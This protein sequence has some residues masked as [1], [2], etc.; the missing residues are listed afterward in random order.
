V[1]VVAA[2]TTSA[3][4]ARVAVDRLT[5]IN[6]RVV[7]VVLNRAKVDARSAFYYPYGDDDERAA[8]ESLVQTA[9]S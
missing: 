1:F 6:T 7:G 3:E 9:R 4:V 5:S 8:R 2:G